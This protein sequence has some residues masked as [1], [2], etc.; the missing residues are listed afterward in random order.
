MNI[1]KKCLDPDLQSALDYLKLDI[2]IFSA[3]FTN[4]HVDMTIDPQALSLMSHDHEYS[5][6]KDLESQDLFAN[7]QMLHT[8]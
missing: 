7:I 5:L 1:S 8:I 2:F 6:P 4:K 3:N